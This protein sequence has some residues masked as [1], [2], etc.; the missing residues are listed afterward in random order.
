[1]CVYIYIYGLYFI[2]LSRIIYLGLY[3]ASLLDG[4]FSNCREWGLLVVVLGLHTAAASLA[5]E[6]GL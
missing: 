1:M 4:L 5:V 2:I 6:H 3:G